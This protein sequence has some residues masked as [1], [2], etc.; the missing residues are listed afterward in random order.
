M[1]REKSERKNKIKHQLKFSKSLKTL[2]TEQI[3]FTD[4]IID[5]LLQNNIAEASEIKEVVRITTS[6]IFLKFV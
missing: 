2:Y 4:E 5:L 3:E 6:F 1:S